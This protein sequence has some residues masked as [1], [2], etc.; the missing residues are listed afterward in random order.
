MGFVAINSFTLKYS[1]FPT[2]TSPRRGTAKTKDNTYQQWITKV[3]RKTTFLF[4]KRPPELWG[5]FYPQWSSCSPTCHSGPSPPS[6]RLGFPVSWFRMKL[7]FLWMFIRYLGFVSP[8]SVKVNVNFKH[9]CCSNTQPAS[10]RNRHHAVKLPCREVREKAMFDCRSN[11]PDL[12]RRFDLLLHDIHQPHVGAFPERPVHH[13]CD[14]S[15]LFSPFWDLLDQVS[16]D[17]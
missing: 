1:F 8:L 5:C 12:L 15:K 9:L 17:Q 13:N 2:D 6:W 14:G 16:A 7:G 10:P 4:I 11:V 3:S